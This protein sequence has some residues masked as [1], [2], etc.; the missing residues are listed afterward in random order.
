[1]LNLTGINRRMLR[2]VALLI[3]L[4]LCIALGLQ[5]SRSSPKDTSI[6]AAENFD[7]VKARRSFRAPAFHNWPEEHPDVAKNSAKFWKRLLDTPVSQLPRIYKQSKWIIQAKKKLRRTLHD[8]GLRINDGHTERLL[9]EFRKESMLVSLLEQYFVDHVRNLRIFGKYI[10]T[11]SA[12]PEFRSKKSKAVIQYLFPWLKSDDRIFEE[13]LVTKANGNGILITILSD[14]KISTQINRVARLIRVLRVQGN[15]LPIQ[16][17]FA[18]S[19][20]ISQERLDL[21]TKAAESDINGYLTDE[22]TVDLNIVYAKQTITFLNV[23]QFIGE[24]VVVTDNLI[25]SLAV[26]FSDFENLVVLLPQTIPMTT[27]LTSLFDSKKFQSQGMLFFKDRPLLDS[28]P[29]PFPPGF[30]EV[31]ELVNKFAAVDPKE[32]LIFGFKSPIKTHTN[33]VTEY[34]FQRLLDPSMAVFNKQKSL[35][36]LFLSSVFPFHSI[37][38]PKYDISNRFNPELLWLGQELAGTC[39]YVHFNRFYA[40]APGVLTPIENRPA[41]S[42]AEELCSSSW[43]QISGDNESLL[44][45]TSHQLENRKIPQFVAAVQEKLTTTNV[46]GFGEVESDDSLAQQTV[47][48]NIMYIRDVLQPIPVEKPLINKEGQPFL[49]VKHVSDFGT[50]ND[51]W[52]SYDVVGSVS[53]GN[54]GLVYKHKKKDI[55]RF[56]KYLNMWLLDPEPGYNL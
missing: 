51:Y 53:E 26:I 41:E 33:R 22:N 43:S 12:P 2:L 50:V 46:I 10:S 34:G 39:D 6:E 3:A 5:S 4:G 54:R 23:N 52:C 56:L 18:G 35:L 44:Y 24:G 49:P 7:I 21:L 8:Q 19:K 25:Y 47:S 36:G 13:L 20:T 27:N 37:L 17:A 30:F 9:H 11:I 1:M 15:K 45:V 55:E 29:N 16:I 28:K 14:S 42:Y 32:S 48:K 40:S 38:K 31:N